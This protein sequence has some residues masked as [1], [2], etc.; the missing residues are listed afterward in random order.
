MV[1]VC[2]F[3]VHRV[4]LSKRPQTVYSVMEL[5]C[6]DHFICGVVV[7]PIMFMIILGVSSLKH[8][9]IL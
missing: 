8:T 7:F 5:I 9:G 4:L 3:S 1:S 6:N 2:L